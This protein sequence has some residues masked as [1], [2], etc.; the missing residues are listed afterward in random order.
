MLRFVRRR[1]QPSHDEENR[2]EVL[3]IQNSHGRLV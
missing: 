2:F 3:A 1:A